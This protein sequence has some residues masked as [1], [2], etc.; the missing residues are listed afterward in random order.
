MRLNDRPRGVAGSAL[1]RLYPRAWRDRYQAEMLAVLEDRPLGLRTRLDLVRG[2]V[3]AH[4]HPIEAPT[5]PVV[6]S[7]VAGVA[8][9][10]AGLAAATQPL[11][12]DWPGF[13]VETLPLGLIG[14]VAGVRVL[15]AV[16]RR[17]GLGG[18]RGTGLALAIAIVGHVALILA[19]VVALAGGTYGAFTGAALSIAG[20]GT[21]LVGLVRGRAGDHPGAEAVLIA[22][23]AMLIPSP[24]AWPL[25]GAA[26]IA[27]AISTVR[28][29][30][31]LRRA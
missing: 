22:G 7:V 15:L 17:S 5:T 16:G 23:A 9:I 19:L 3:D 8:W 12:P 21:V 4:V 28:P 2:A 24:I 30:M 25:A 29:T 18:P 27:L 1:L 11:L 20:I 10:V 13:L 26:W 14:A 6:A 31:P